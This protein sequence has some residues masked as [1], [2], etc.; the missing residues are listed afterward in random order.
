MTLVDQILAEN[1][2]LDESWQYC[3][4]QQDDWYASALATILILNVAM[5]CLIV[6]RHLQRYSKK[7]LSVTLVPEVKV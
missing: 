5:R 1:Q 3:F 6:A 2:Q 7:K 4:P